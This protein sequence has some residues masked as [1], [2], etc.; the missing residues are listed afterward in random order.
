MPRIAQ[1][2]PQKGLFLLLCFVFLKI[3]LS[4]TSLFLLIQNQAKAAPRWSKEKENQASA[5]DVLTRLQFWENM[6]NCL[7]L[8]TQ[9]LEVP[10]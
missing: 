8:T 5:N 1:E 10:V 9:F 3:F 4:L 7:F 6:R 2:S